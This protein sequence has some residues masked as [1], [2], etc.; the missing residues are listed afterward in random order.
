MVLIE[1][2]KQSTIAAGYNGLRD[3]MIELYHNYF[4]TDNTN[5]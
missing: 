1:M 4:L 3:E 5:E 2:L